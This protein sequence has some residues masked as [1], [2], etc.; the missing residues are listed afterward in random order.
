MAPVAVPSA[1]ARGVGADSARAAAW[2]RLGL[3]GEERAF[4]RR[5]AGTVASRLVAVPLGVLG[6]IVVARGLGPAGRGVYGVMTT[7]AAI[8]VQ[9]GNLGLPAATV[10]TIGRAPRRLPA[11]LGLALIVA[12]GL[13]GA[14]ALAFGGLSAMGRG[15]TMLSPALAWLAGA[16]IPL[17][18]LLLLLQ[19]VLLGVRA[20]RSYN[21]LQIALD[22]ANISVL[23]LCFLVGWRSPGAFYG[24]SLG[25]LAV[26]TGAALALVLRHVGGRPALPDTAL[27]G[28][29]L[30]YGARAYLSTLFAYLLINFDL[31]MV[32]RMR[33]AADA[34]YYAVAGRMAEM[35]FLAPAAVGAILFTTVSSMREGR[36]EF[37]RRVAG[38]LALALVP[39]LALAAVLA[40]PVVALLFGR[41]FL[42]AVPAFLC[43]L[44]GVYLL[45]VNIPLMNYFGGTGMPPVT[46]IGPALGLV[47]NIALN[48]WWIPRYGI[49]GAAAA[50]SAAYSL[51]LAASLV[52][53]WR[54]K[55]AA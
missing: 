55:A 24:V 29:A 20:V 52:H 47:V 21:L 16:W 8:G 13:G 27:V 4:W 19:N 26:A 35:L 51:M 7:V 28:N 42:P 5:A 32:A 37:A 31:L 45:G 41:A 2:R 33:G 50:S 54:R 36:W 10:Y 39:L 40:R 15:P 48:L 49:V 1:T 38:A 17:G 44:P 43:L 6:S 25:V 11:L 34:G 9:L 3:E 53:L 18:L 30:R 14:L 22:V 12:L 46:V 23:A